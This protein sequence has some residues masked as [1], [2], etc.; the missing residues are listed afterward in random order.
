[1]IRAEE[2]INDLNK[3][4]D[5]CRYLAVSDVSIVIVC[6]PVVNVRKKI[7]FY[8]VKNLERHV[9]DTSVISAF[10]LFCLEI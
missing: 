1:M 10:F 5:H 7:V 4:I 2:K 9:S 6:K 8:I 3:I